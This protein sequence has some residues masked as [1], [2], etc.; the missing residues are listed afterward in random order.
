MKERLLESCLILNEKK[1]E[2]P[3]V[4]FDVVKKEIQKAKNEITQKLKKDEYGKYISISSKGIEYD[5]REV[6]LIKKKMKYYNIVMVVSEINLVTLA[7]KLKISV[8]Q[9]ESRINGIISLRNNPNYK[10]VNC[11]VS[12]KHNVKQEAKLVIF[13][14]SEFDVVR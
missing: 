2:K 6:G 5:S 3:E 13:V 9:L 7:R 14:R 1:H 11:T 10:H 4:S 8:S 12:V